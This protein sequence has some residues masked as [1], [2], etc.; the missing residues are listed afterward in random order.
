MGSWKQYND[1]GSLT[2]ESKAYKA[3]YLDKKP[4]GGGGG[5]GQRPSPVS[6]KSSD[7]GGG[8]TSSS[9]TLDYS[10]IDEARESR[11]KAE[12]TKGAAAAAAYAGD[13]GKT[14]AAGH[15]IRALQQ[16]AREADLQGPRI[17][18]SQSSHTNPNSK[19]AIKFK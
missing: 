17:R 9:R 18:Q 5:G 15:A 3:K 11:S 16:K 7:T 14:M 6:E 10:A 8:R 2:A 4:F 19:S 12:A 1:D 13:V